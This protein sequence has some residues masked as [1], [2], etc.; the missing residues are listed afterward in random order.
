MI[1]IQNTLKDTINNAASKI[2]DDAYMN[3][4]VYKLTSSINKSNIVEPNVKRAINQYF[5][6]NSGTKMMVGGNGDFFKSKNI[7]TH[8]LL[9]ATTIYYLSDLNQYDY[10]LIN[11]AYKYGLEI[12][13]IITLLLLNNIHDISVFCEKH[14]LKNNEQYT[15]ST[16]KKLSA[17]FKIQYNF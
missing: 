14:N 10:K 11:E 8:D 4:I 3:D 1:N 13:D 2:H 17:L 12:G 16:L 6:I 7:N 15:L 9:L 5:G